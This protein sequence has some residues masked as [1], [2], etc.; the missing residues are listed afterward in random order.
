MKV[1]FKELGKLGRFGNQLFQIA[2][3]IGIASKNGGEPVFPPW[4][5]FDHVNH[6]PGASRIIG[7]IFEN[8]LNEIAASA[9]EFLPVVYIPMH[10]EPIVLSRARD[11]S[12]WGFMQTEKYFTH[13]AP[14]IRIQ[15]ATRDRPPITNKTICSIHVRRGDYVD[16]IYA[17]PGEEYYRPAIE[18]M[19]AEG[20]RKF[21]V[22]SDD[23][24]VA[25]SMLLPIFEMIKGNVDVKFSDVP[26]YE[27]RDENKTDSQYLRDFLAMKS[28]GGHIISNS[29]FSWWAAW[30]AN[31]G[32]VICPRQ[33]FKKAIGSNDADIPANGWFLMD[34]NA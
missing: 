23:L 24:D 19:I 11:V 16:S 4:K 8:P 12:L 29:S 14:F 17:L 34:V 15:F 22:F 25:I 18:K 9:L 31:Y 10:Y 3:T 21:C 2:S 32:P 7:D 28:C 6:S 5:N 33:W 26:G 20:F 1:T 30:L 13:C 27:I